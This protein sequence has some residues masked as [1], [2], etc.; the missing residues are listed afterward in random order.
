MSKGNII[1]SLIVAFILVGGG[2]AY[3]VT[4]QNEGGTSG[5]LRDMADRAVTPVDNL[6]NGVVTVGVGTLRWAS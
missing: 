5:D 1:M 4:T 2:A 6:D 3:Y